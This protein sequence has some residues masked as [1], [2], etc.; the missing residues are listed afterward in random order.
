MFVLKLL[1][2]QYVWKQCSN[3]AQ[4]ILLNKCL[5]C[6]FEHLFH[7]CFKMFA[8]ETFVILKPCCEHFSHSGTA[9]HSVSQA[10][11]AFA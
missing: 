5:K 2:L 3:F 4:N 8:F 10:G 11:G 1:E 6:S 7:S 9:G